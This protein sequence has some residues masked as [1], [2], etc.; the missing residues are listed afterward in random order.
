MK[1][2]FSPISLLLLFAAVPASAESGKT[3]TAKTPA[4][5]AA[6]VLHLPDAVEPVEPLP[7]P[8]GTARR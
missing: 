6:G 3:G 2:L 4:R 5:T 7:A 1:S 8:A